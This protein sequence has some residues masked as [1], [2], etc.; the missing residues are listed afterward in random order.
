MQY[1]LDNIQ[2][3]DA[4]VRAALS[5]IR[6]DGTPTGTRNNFEVAVAFFLPTD[7][8]AKKQKNKRP[9][10]EISAATGDRSPKELGAHK[11]GRFHWR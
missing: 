1:P 8:V 2:A 3:K 10:A 11:P 6:M 5:S 7:P 4:N 9:A